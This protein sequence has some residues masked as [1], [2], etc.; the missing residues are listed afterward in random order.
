M[1]A[2]YIAMFLLSFITFTLAG[3][4]QCSGNF[5]E[6]NKFYMTQQCCKKAD[7]SI[8]GKFCITRND[9]TFKN[10]CKGYGATSPCA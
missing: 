7:G 5:S 4:C 10:C 3:R 9:G 2:L 6:R 1:R 8:A